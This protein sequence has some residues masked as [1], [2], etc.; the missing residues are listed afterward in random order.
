M[1]SRD[2]RDA[3]LAFIRMLSGEENVLKHMEAEGQDEMV[4]H[5][6]F[7]KKM[8]PSKEVYEN[9]GFV[10]TDIPGDDLLC[11][12]I[13][14]DGWKLVKTDHSM[15]NDL[16]DEK[17]RKRGSMFY[18][19]AFYDRDAFID[20]SPRYGVHVNYDEK[21]ESYGEVYFGDS[22]NKLFVAGQ[23]RI[24]YDEPLEV[25]RTK[26]DERDRLCELA[27]QFGDENYPDW[28]DVLAYWDD[29]KVTGQISKK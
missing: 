9:L 27:R 1:S 15:W 7:A 25:R 21:D 3:F 6:L 4:K 18:K 28:E 12:A 24:S 20:L 13:L 17:G 11:N 2:E 5:T 16:L 8:R 14:P 23:V 26:Y 22:E 10:F 19:A 29:E